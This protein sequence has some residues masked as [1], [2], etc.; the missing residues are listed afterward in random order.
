MSPH[1]KNYLGVALI[2]GLL[3]FAVAAFQFV[4]A[5]S[6]SIAPSS[7]RSFSASGEGKV[8]AVP[9]VAQFSFAVLTEGGKDI[10]ALQTENNKKVDAAI[11]FIKSQGVDKKDIETQSYNVSP[12][13]TYSNCPSNPYGYA[14]DCPPPEIVGYTVNQYVSVK[15]RNFEKIGGLLSGVV[16]RGANNVSGLSFVIDDPTELQN[17][18]REKAMEKAYAKAESIAKAG[19]FRLGKLLSVDEGGSGPIYYARD[20]MMEFGKGGVA[21]A[22]A[23]A[24]TIEPGSQDVTVNVTLRFEIQ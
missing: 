21:P 16:A 2:A 11:E 15:I 14:T 7:F 10:V 3:L 23:P 24:P 9:D 18:A 13:Y 6:R 19:G 8:V 20:T 22:A 4:G 5:Y 17:Q 12:R 1:I